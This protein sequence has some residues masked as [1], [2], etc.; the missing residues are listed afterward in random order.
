M[1]IAPLPV[2]SRP[3][4]A[5]VWANHFFALANGEANLG[6]AFPNTDSDGDFLITGQEW[7]IGTDPL[8]KDTDLDFTDDGE[9]F[10]AF[11]LTVSN[12]RVRLTEEIFGNGFE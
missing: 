10:P 9:E 1:N 4:L 8:N 11:G 12:P 3:P 7:L 6:Y 5:S 2:A